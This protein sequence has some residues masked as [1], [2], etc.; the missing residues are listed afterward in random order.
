[1]SN[2]VEIK[3]VQLENIIVKDNIQQRE[4]LDY[5]CVK[6][7]TDAL[8]GGAVFPAIVLFSDG[9]QMILADGLH[10]YYAYQAAK[11]EEIEA[12]IHPGGERE[13]V[14][15]ACGANAEHGLRRTN[16]DKRKAV[17]TF[18]SDAEWRQM[19]DNLISGACRVSQP[20]VSRIRKEMSTYNDYKSEQKRIGADGRETDVS[21]IGLRTKQPAQASE[22]LP[23]DNASFDQTITANEDQNVPNQA[24]TV[25]ETQQELSVTSTVSD[26]DDNDAVNVTDQTSEDIQDAGLTD[27][28]GHNVPTEAEEV[29]EPWQES[30][31]DESLPDVVLKP[32][33]TKIEGFKTSDNLQ[34]SVCGQ[35]LLNLKI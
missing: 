7:Y 17:L 11:R 19:S 15:Y 28:Q 24:E 6:E 1:M 13:A 20:F 3:T 8:I 32:D 30:V 16:K 22:S 31:T 9:N 18:L 34:S 23:A 33:V 27:E 5:E 21:R 2:Q 12:Q 14:F 35:K 25:P 26:G 29:Q 10:R 4:F